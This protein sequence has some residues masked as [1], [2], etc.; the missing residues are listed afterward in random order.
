MKRIALAGLTAAVLGG[1]CTS[2]KMPPAPSTTVTGLQMRCDATAIDAG[3]KT[4]CAV[5]ATY[6][7]RTVNDQTANADWSTSDAAVATV[8]KGSITAVAPGSAEITA[9]LQSVS[10]KTTV[11]VRPGIR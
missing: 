10:T 2:N 4:T 8:S 7:D 5:L 6:D 9:R 11:S 1:A 3:Q